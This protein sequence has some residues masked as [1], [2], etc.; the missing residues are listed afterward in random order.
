MSVSMFDEVL[1]RG[2]RDG[3]GLRVGAIIA[4]G[5]EVLLL[6]PHSTGPIV[7]TRKL[8]GAT[9]EPGESVAG[10]L[11]RGVREETGLTVTNIGAHVGD[12][13]YLSPAGKPVRRLHFVVDVAATGPIVLSAHAGYVWAPLTD[14]L[15][16]TS[17]IRKILDTYG[18]L[19][20]R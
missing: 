16:V 20:G 19:V 17:S 14:E 13:D 6:E 5:G 4:R 18:D 8:P 1:P 7:P 2:E 11:I 3:V 15:H 12:F 10:A 9:V